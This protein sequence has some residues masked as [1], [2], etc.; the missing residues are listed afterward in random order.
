[1]T[2]GLLP[3]PTIHVLCAELEVRSRRERGSLGIPA[4][5][6]RSPALWPRFLA[7]DLG[8][9]RTQRHRI[10]AVPVIITT[11]WIIIQIITITGPFG[12]R[13]APV[14]FQPKR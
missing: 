3:C 10:L 9:R 6:R 12:F 13:L 11:S 5:P 2:V 8:P 1:M 14:T 4:T 7:V